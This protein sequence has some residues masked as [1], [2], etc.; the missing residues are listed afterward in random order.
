MEGRTIRLP[1]YNNI[2]HISK[3]LEHINGVRI[4]SIPI[5]VIVYV[6][7]VAGMELLA[8]ALIPPV[9]EI[10]LL[11]LVAIPVGAAWFLRKVKL[12]GRSPIKFFNALFNYAFGDKTYVHF[13]PVKK[14][15]RIVFKEMISYRKVIKI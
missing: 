1:S 15:E 11:V 14:D 7:A 2:W 13:K 6:V 9:R 3:T 8:C 5:E 12:D 10:P 4:S